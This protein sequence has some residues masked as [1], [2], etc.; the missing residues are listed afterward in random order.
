[1]T[2]EAYVYTRTH[3]FLIDTCNVPNTYQTQ[4]MYIHS[5][6]LTHTCNSGIVGPRDLPDMYTQA[7]GT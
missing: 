7:Q 6:K 3:V 5:H 4:H 2:M 1:M